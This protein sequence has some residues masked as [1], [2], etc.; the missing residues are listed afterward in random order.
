VHCRNLALVQL[1]NSTA[2]GARVGLDF[3]P[4]RTW[5]RRR[6]LWWVDR[7]FLTSVALWVGCWACWGDIV[8]LAGVLGLLVIGFVSVDLFEGCRVWY[9]EISWWII[10]ISGWIKVRVRVRVEGRRALVPER[11]KINNLISQWLFM[12]FKGS[13]VRIHG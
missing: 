3:Q 4:P 7:P 13:L 11:V 8:G 10:Y 2:W 1:G 9:M 6:W 5:W 12:W